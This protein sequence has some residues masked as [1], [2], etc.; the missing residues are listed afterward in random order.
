MIADWIF[1]SNLPAFLTV[2]SWIAGY[3]LAPDE[4]AIIIKGAAESDSDR[5][6]WFSWE[7]GGIPIELGCDQGSGVVQVR[8]QSPQALSD[9]F[10]LATQIFSTFRLAT[11]T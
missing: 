9:Q 4:C 5:D 6:D 11:N 2:I 10:R 7:F 3:E 8:I 1:E